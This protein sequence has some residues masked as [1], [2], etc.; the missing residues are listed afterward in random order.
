MNANTLMKDLTPDALISIIADESEYPGPHANALVAS[1]K[2]ILSAVVG[3]KETVWLLKA[4]GITTNIGPSLSLGMH[5]DVNAAL[6]DLLPPT[7]AEIIIAEYKNP[8]PC[9]ETVL[10]MTIAKFVES[11][12]REYASELL[13]EAGI[14]IASL[15]QPA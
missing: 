12:G 15:S 8:G 6:D 3:K 7:L 9:A 11:A 1:A 2:A 4:N 10:A 13:K 14:D 5:I